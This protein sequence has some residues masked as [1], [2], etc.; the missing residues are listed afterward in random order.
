VHPN[1]IIASVEAQRLA[2]VSQF[3]VSFD[4]VSSCFTPTRSASDFVRTWQKTPRIDSMFAEAAPAGVRLRA[5][6]RRAA[7]AVTGTALVDGMD[8]AE[9]GQAAPRHT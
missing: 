5:A 9:R 6:T 1:W 2:P 3:L 8:A 4:R 7:A